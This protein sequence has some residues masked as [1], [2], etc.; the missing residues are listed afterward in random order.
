MLYIYVDESEDETKDVFALSGL[1]FTR[2]QRDK[3]VSEWRNALKGYKLETFHTAELYARPSFDESRRREIFGY[4]RRLIGENVQSGV[5]VIISKSEFAEILPRSDERVYNMPYAF[6]LYNLVVTVCVHVGVNEPLRFVFDKNSL[7]KKVESAWPEFLMYAPP[8]YRQRLHHKPRFEDD[9]KCEPLQAADFL[10]W[11]E[12]RGA[13]Q[14][15]TG[16]AAPM[17]YDICKTALFPVVRSW[18]RKEHL[19]AFKEL[20][21]N[22]EAIQLN[23]IFS[24]LLQQVGGMP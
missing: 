4:F 20:R 17:P 18:F 7:S 24:M 9:S 3:F 2:K 8:Q 10:A 19:R 13:I 6:L 14:N 16:V 11:R 12:R 1:V 23:R 15:L 22:T 5:S 21:Q